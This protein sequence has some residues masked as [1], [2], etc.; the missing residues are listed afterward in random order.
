MKYI[1]V[2]GAKNSGKTTL[3]E[4]LISVFVK[5]G[6]AVASIKHT[7]HRHYFD[8]PGKDSY[9]HRK[10][11][12]RVCIA[13]S[14]TEGALFFGSDFDITLVIDAVASN[15]HLCILEGDTSSVHP[16][17]LLTRNMKK[18]NWNRVSNIIAT[19]GPVIP[20]YQ[21]KPHFSTNDTASLVAFLSDSLDLT[22]EA[23][24]T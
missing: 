11:G 3:V 13:I 12:A 22:V 1:S 10:S 9:R 18:R 5:S 8:T 19:Y 20:P 4:Q 24:S 7:A 17:L 2:I 16:K 15:H 6:L 23:P 14:E 21:S